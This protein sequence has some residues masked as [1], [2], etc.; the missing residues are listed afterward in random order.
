MQPGVKPKP[1]FLRVL[2]GNP[3]KRPI[4]DKEPKGELIIKFPR[5]PSYLGQGGQKEWRRT[6]YNLF[7]A[8]MLDR[9][10]LPVL[11]KYCELFEQSIRAYEEVKRGG[12]V[13]DSKGVVRANPYI[14][15]WL[16]CGREMRLLQAEMG[17]TLSSRSRI[18]GE[19]EI[20]DMEE[21]GVK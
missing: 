13:K 5:A 15:I 4:N 20:D 19:G 14:K 16:E 8:R 9:L 1:T 12:L 18:K 6:G 3:G 17:L 2:E 10:G 11:E 21:F 7:K